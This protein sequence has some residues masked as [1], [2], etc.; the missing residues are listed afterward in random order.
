[1]KT[2]LGGQPLASFSIQARSSASGANTSL[3]AVV[4]LTGGAVTVY[5]KRPVPPGATNAWSIGVARP[6][7]SHEELAKA[8]E[9]SRGPD[10]PSLTTSF[11]QVAVPMFWASKYEPAVCPDSS[12]RFGLRPANLAS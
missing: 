9:R 4:A 8:L 10:V 3:N 5:E 2:P 12:V 11:V 6:A 7:F 1:M